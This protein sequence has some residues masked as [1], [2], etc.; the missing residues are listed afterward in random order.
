PRSFGGGV[1]GSTRLC[2]LAARARKSSGFQRTLTPIQPPDQPQSISGGWQSDTRSGPCATLVS[3]VLNGRQLVK[4]PAK[5]AQ[6]SSSV[7]AGTRPD[8]F[9]SAT[10]QMSGEALP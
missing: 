9:F 3:A 5:Q 2:S 10:I 8:Y 1:G 4:P 6:V 7:V